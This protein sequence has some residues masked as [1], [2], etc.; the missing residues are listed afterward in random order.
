MT[1]LAPADEKELAAT[2]ASAAARKE[3]L[4]IVGGGT[5]TGLGRPVQAS[6]TLTTSNLT[7]VTLYEPAEM[8]IA[9][10]AG[11]PLAEVEALLAKNRQ[12]LAF[13][14]PDHRVM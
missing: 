3:P 11:T 12:R 1:A 4:A 5:R 10:K 7:G 13:E 14:P 8:V 2:V 9:A 6:A